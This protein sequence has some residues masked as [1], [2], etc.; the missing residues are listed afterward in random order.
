MTIED[1]RQHACTV[2]A[3]FKEGEPVIKFADV[4]QPESPVG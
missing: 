1:L 3:G 2:T 4:K